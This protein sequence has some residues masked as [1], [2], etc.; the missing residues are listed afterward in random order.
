MSQFTSRLLFV[1]HDASRTGAPILLLH[2][3]GWLKANSDV[4]FRILLGD[5]GP[6]EGDYRALAP[7]WV[8]RRELGPPPG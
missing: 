3:L 8:L 6:L 2:L 5:G 1:G 7:T 4:S